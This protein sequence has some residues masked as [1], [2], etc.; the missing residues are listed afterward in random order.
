MLRVCLVVIVRVFPLSLRTQTLNDIFVV[1]ADV[2]VTSLKK[3]D[4]Y[5]AP[6]KKSVV[7]TAHIVVHV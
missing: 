5:Q 1:V 2:Y 4:A 3:I 7:C 6:V